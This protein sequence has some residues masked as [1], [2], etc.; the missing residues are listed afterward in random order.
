MKKFCSNKISG[1][2]HSGSVFLKVQLFRNS[3]LNILE[4]AQIW[5]FINSS[6]LLPQV[7]YLYNIFLDI[8]LFVQWHINLLGL[9]NGKVNPV[10]EQ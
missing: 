7:F 3:F 10:E 4:A 9:F 1:V 5:K 8:V 2:V 6:F